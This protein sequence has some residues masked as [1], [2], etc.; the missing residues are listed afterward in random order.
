MV[1]AAALPVQRPT[2]HLGA[3]AER[4]VDAKLIAATQMDLR[5]DLYRRLAVAEL[6][7]AI[8][9][10]RDMGMAFWLPQAEAALDRVEARSSHGTTATWQRQHGTTL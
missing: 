9:L 5:A 2:D 4:P 3:V 7:T 1:R 6:T 10:Y 8:A